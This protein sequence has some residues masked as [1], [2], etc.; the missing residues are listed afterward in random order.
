MVRF[1]LHL[2]HLME[3]FHIFCGLAMGAIGYDHGSL[4]HIVDTIVP[5]IYDFNV[6]NV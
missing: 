5:H 3:E 2:L 6:D 1:C 4:G